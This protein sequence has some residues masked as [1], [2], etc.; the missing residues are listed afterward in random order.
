MMTMRL[1]WFGEKVRRLGLGHLSTQYSLPNVQ[2]SKEAGSQTPRQSSRS[3]S[4]N[5]LRLRTQGADIQPNATV[6]MHRWPAREAHRKV[7]V[8]K[9]DAGDEEAGGGG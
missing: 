3:P 1:H 9:C 6:H 8:Q 2:Q 5:G 7:M 4:L